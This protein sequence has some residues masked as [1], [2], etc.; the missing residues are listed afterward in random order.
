MKRDRIRC[1]GRPLVAN[2]SSRALTYEGAASPRATH[3]SGVRQDDHKPG[4]GNS[5]NT[6]CTVT[7][8]LG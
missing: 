1:S 4:L 5:P 6:R 3:T 7:T 8:Q 2:A